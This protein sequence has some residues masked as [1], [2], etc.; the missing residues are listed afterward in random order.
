MRRSRYNSLGIRIRTG[1]SLIRGVITIRIDLNSPGEVF[2]L[3]VRMQ[4]SLPSLWLLGRRAR[5]KTWRRSIQCH[6]FGLALIHM[7]GVLYLDARLELHGTSVNSPIRSLILTRASSAGYTSYQRKQLRS[8]FPLCKSNASDAGTVCGSF[9]PHIHF[10][11]SLS[12]ENPT[13]AALAGKVCW[14]TPAPG[15]S[16]VFAS[17]TASP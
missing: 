11:R 3:A 17:V 16:A 2:L 12:A 14:C 1:C 6:C 5:N 9:A 8:L 7:K 13:Q 10:R 15:L 4:C